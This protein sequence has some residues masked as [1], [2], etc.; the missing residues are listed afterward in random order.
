MSKHSSIG[1]LFAIGFWG[2]IIIFN[3]FLEKP[4]PFIYAALGIFAVILLTL[5]LNFLHTLYLITFNSR[6]RTIIKFN[7]T[8]S[9]IHFEDLLKLNR[10]EKSEI[11]ERYLRF[12]SNSKIFD[13]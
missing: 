3:V 12:I 10:T 13:C 9:K 6:F 2:I 11:D 5:F 4:M 1:C 7:E 8:E